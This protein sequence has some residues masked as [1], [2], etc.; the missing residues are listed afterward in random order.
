MCLIILLLS[1]INFLCVNKLVRNEP[2]AII[3]FIQNNLFTDDGIFLNHT[4]K[5]TGR[6]VLA[7]RN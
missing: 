2:R 7:L 6:E 5:F 4:F 3:F 1:P